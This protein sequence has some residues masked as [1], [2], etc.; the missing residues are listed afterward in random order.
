MIDY[1]IILLMLVI[2]YLAYCLMRIG[3]V[4]LD[5]EMIAIERQHNRAA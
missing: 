1:R 3:L 4:I 5:D 2:E